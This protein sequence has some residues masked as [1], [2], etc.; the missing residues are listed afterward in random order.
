MLACLKSS[1]QSLGQELC[2]EEREWGSEDESPCFCGLHTSSKVWPTLPLS[3]CTFRN[4]A[5]LQEPW[6]HPSRSTGRS[7]RKNWSLGSGLP[8]HL[9]TT[10]ARLE[11]SPED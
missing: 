11:D 7:L 6:G 8:S 9:C 3:A 1:V 4:S 2:P 5:E 10:I